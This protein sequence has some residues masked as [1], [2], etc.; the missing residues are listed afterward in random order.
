MKRKYTRKSTRKGS[1][2]KKRSYKSRVPKRF[3]SG[4]SPKGSRYSSE[5]YERIEVRTAFT[6]RNLD[7]DRIESPLVN[8][9]YGTDFVGI[10]APEIGQFALKARPKFTAFATMY[11]QYEVLGVAMSVEMPVNTVSNLLLG[12]PVL[13]GTSGLMPATTSDNYPQANTLLNMYVSATGSTG[14][15]KASVYFPKN[16]Y[17]I[18]VGATRA[19]PTSAVYNT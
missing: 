16:K 9:I 7:K 10:D 14:G 19:I 8:Y 11:S 15:K 13:G 12:A 5:C 6:I 3:N 1:Y 2:R 18:S 4:I 17:A